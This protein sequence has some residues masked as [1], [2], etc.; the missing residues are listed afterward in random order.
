MIAIALIHLS[1]GGGYP[2]SYVK[3]KVLLLFFT[4]ITALPSKVVE[5]KHDYN[6]KGFSP[7]FFS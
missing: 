7:I 6:T 5:L 2:L 3:N 1:L 4:I